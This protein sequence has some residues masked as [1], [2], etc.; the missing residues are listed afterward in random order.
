VEKLWKKRGS[1]VDGLS[2]ANF[3]RSSF[4]E[5][6][7]VAPFVCSF[8]PRF[9][10]ARRRRRYNSKTRRKFFRRTHLDVSAVTF[11][12]TIHGRSYVIVVHPVGPSRWR[13]EVSRTPGATTSLM[14]FYGQTPDEAAQHLAGWLERAG[15]RAPKTMGV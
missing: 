5:T 15:I 10:C 6:G 9:A 8:A 4:A 13:A 12:E 14:P 11:H 1:T 2:D 7:V 3:F